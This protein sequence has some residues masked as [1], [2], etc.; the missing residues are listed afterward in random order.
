MKI[1]KDKDI[2]GLLGAGL[3]MILVGALMWKFLGQVLGLG[4]ILGGLVLFIARL[5][6]ATKPKTDTMMDER[7]ARINEKAGYRAFWIIMGCSGILWMVDIY[8]SLNMKF[9][10]LCAVITCIG[11]YSFFIL[12][13]YHHK[14]GEGT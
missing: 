14:K 8:W 10:D 7:T 1:R 13:F 11:I 9:K 5:Y 3:G 4:L 6:T 12:R 2:L